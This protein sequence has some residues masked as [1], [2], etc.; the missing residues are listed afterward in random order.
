MYHPNIFFAT[1]VFLFLI[2]VTS[3][4]DDS[5]LRIQLTDVVNLPMVKNVYD[6][7][8]WR[9]VLIRSGIRYKR[10]CDEIFQ[11]GDRKSGLYI[12]E[13]EHTRKLVV[14][15]Y[16]D[17]CNGWTVIQRNTHDTVMTWSET[18]TTYQYGFG[19]LEAEHWLGTE[20]ISRI[21]EQKWYK[22]RINLV[23]ANGNHKYAE[24]DSFVLRNQ[25]NSYTLKL[26]T[27]EGNAGDSLSSSLHKN[28]HDN[29]KFSCKDRDNDR[30]TLENCADIYGGCW[31]YDSCFDAQLNR[32]GGIHWSTLCD[33]D[34][35]K[36]EIL[37]KPIHMY[38]NRV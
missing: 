10:D 24:Y 11:A 26:G 19:N 23:D 3:S 21:S 2:H 30:S 37:L 5:S 4:V 8:N 18:W 29:M 31:W 13:P 17:G 28:M 34:C 38:C 9:T 33:E 7:R 25:T 20:Y 32:K 1:A 36:S 15:C 16:M 6:I 35:K 14:Q 27:Y 22:V 12:I